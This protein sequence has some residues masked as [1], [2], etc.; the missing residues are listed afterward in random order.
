MKFK[1]MVLLLESEIREREEKRR[2]YRD[3]GDA[4]K[5]RHFRRLLVKRDWRDLMYCFDSDRLLEGFAEF[6]Q[7]WLLTFV[8]GKHFS[9]VL[10]YFWRNSEANWRSQ[11]AWADAFQTAKRI[12]G[13]VTPVDFELKHFGSYLDL[14][15]AYRGCGPMNVRG[16][17]WTVN[18]QVAEQFR[19]Q[20]GMIQGDGQVV[21]GEVSKT[22]VLAYMKSQNQYELI[23]VPDLIK[24]LT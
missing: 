8:G 13:A 21:R 6:L 16:L 4:E 19:H 20:A 1:P 7:P 12:D 15:V 23:V 22:D 17:S 5:A 2:W 18:P 3:L 11:N 10:R 14:I 24:V 9:I